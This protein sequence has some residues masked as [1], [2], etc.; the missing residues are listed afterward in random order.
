MGSDEEQ[1][2]QVWFV[3]SSQHVQ[4]VGCGISIES[5]NDGVFFHD[6]ADITMLVV[7]WSEFSVTT[8]TFSS[9]WSTGHGIMIYRFML[10]RRWRSGMVLSLISTPHVPI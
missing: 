1:T 9:C 8:A 3:T 7:R 2:Q 5:R 4:P 10:L 6:E